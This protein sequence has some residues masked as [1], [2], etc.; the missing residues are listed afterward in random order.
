MGEGCTVTAT[1]FS[2]SCIQ[3]CGNTLDSL[4]KDTIGVFFVHG[5][6]FYLCIMKILQSPTPNNWKDFSF[7][8]F[9][10]PAFFNVWGFSKNWTWTAS[11]LPKAEGTL[12]YKIVLCFCLKKMKKYCGHNK[13][14]HIAEHILVWIGR[15]YFSSFFFLK[16]QVNVN[17]TVGAHCC[18]AG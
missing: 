4:R 2:Y 7:T 10:T 13:G 1:S 16:Q 11:I 18:S 5:V 14:E 8:F 17:Y 3:I 6:F 12:S 9:I 15:D